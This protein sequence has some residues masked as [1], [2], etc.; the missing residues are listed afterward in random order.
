[1][2]WGFSDVSS[3][4]KTRTPKEN[5]ENLEPFREQKICFVNMMIEMFEHFR[6]DTYRFVVL[7]LECRVPHL[8]H[9]M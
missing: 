7:F 2:I 8:Y 6:T 3:P 4:P 5:Q 9:K 1:M